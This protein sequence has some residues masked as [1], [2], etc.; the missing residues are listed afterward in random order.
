MSTQT[1]QSNEQEDR[2][3]G[4]EWS[5]TLFSLLFIFVGPIAAIVGLVVLWFAEDSLR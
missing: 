2:Y 3:R 1:E 5:L 4:H